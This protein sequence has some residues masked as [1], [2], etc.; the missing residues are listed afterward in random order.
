MVELMYEWICVAWDMMSPDTV[1]K[2]FKTGISNTPNRSEDDMLW[3]GNIDDEIIRS[4]SGSAS[5]GEMVSD[6]DSD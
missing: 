1:M 5:N 6:N 2:G 3:H 4:K